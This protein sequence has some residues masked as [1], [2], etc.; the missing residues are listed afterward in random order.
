MIAFVLPFILRAGSWFKR[1][2][3]WAFAI[4]IIAAF[5]WLQTTRLDHARDGWRIERTNHE[6]TRGSVRELTVKV[7][8]QN[9]A[10]DMLK[11][12][13]DARVKA[14]I[15]AVGARQEHHGD[16][17]KRI[18]RIMLPAPLSG[19]CVTPASVSESGL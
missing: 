9:A 6:V 4:A 11:R 13:S 5:A 3:M 15:K 18:T 17:A 19:R 7:A 16:E 1:I 10:A 8:M 12:D 2:P 14:G